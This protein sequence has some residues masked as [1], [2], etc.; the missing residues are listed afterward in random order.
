MLNAINFCPSCNTVLSY[1]KNEYSKLI[2]ICKRCNYKNEKDI[3]MRIE[4]LNNEK[5]N[6][7]KYAL[8]NI[9]TKYDT[10]LLKTTKISCINPECKSNTNPLD[11]DNLPE[12]LLT[13]KSN[14]NRLMNLTCV[15]C[16]TSWNIK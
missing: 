5:T 2:L 7:I 13:N 6:I 8:P 4:K 1:D 15:Q 11:I 12:I 3:K 9:Y 14:I 16:N 10:T